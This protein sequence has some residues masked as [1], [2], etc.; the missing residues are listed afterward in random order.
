MAA[1]AF[2]DL[3]SEAWNAY[4][5]QSFPNVIFVDSLGVRD[6][7]VVFPFDKP[8]QGLQ[9]NYDIAAFAVAVNNGVA[10]RNGVVTGGVEGG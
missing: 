8:K 3:I 10:G 7:S 6:K 1:S 9:S 4:T 2:D 5:P